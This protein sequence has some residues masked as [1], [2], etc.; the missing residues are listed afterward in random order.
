MKKPEFNQDFQEWIEV[1]ENLILT[2]GENYTKE[3]LQKL[4]QEAKN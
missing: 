4:Y 3:L 2:D 1:L